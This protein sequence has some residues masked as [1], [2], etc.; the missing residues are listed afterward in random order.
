M[1]TQNKFK[2]GLVKFKDLYDYVKHYIS[3]GLQTQK[4]IVGNPGSEGSGILVNL[5]AGAAIFDATFKSS[6]IDDS[7]Y[8]QA[9]LHKHDTTYGASLALARSN[10]D[11][12]THGNVT[13]GMDLGI[14]HGLGWTGDNSY[15]IFGSI[16]IGVDSSGTISDS[17]APGRI[18]RSVTPNG[19][20]IPVVF[21]TVDNNG[22]VRLT[23]RSTAGVNVEILSANKSIA[24]TD[25]ESQ[26]LDPNGADR[27]VT[28][29]ASPTA[30]DYFSFKNTGTGGFNL[31]LKNN[32]GTTLAK[33]GNGVAIAVL[34]NGTTWSF[35]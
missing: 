24:E 30:G 33:I 17:S 27:N 31:F 4:L 6:D 22:V 19:S 3:K 1:G 8:L 11:T 15:K 12:N 21:E 14:I 20:L 28:L 2:K 29:Y 26:E 16:R 35:R 18:I 7:R 9:L 10:S 34:Y 23:K 5:G 13:N 25:K 32:A